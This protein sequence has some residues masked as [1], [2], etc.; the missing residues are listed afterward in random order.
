M[1][2]HVVAGATRS[3][4]A[5]SFHLI[6]SAGLIRIAQ[7]FALGAQLHGADSWKAAI[8]NEHDALLWAQ[9]AYNHMH[10]HMLKMASGDHPDDD[11]LGA[12]GWAVTVLAHIE[13]KYRKLWTSL[14]GSKKP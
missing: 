14:D 10:L 5:P 7:R 11:H 8:T 12:I 2:K 9:E 1:K 6:P 13:A 3:E 4:Q